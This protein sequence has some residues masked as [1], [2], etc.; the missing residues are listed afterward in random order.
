MPHTQYTTVLALAIFDKIILNKDN[1]GFDEVLFGDQSLIQSASVCVITAG[2]KI[3][4]LAGVSGPGGR[5]MRNMTVFINV[6]RQVI[7]DSLNSQAGSEAEERLAV[8]QTAEAVENLIHQ[9]VTVGGLI[10]H[11]FVVQMDP[12]DT[13]YPNSMFRTVRLTFIGKTKLNLT[14]PP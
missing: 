10:I 2:P 3:T 14:I 13:L 7:V 12:G 9:D 8:E 5:V 4:Q 6:Y 1:L 11:G